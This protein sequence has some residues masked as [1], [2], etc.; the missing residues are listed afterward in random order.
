MFRKKKKNY[1]R[2]LE[3][4]EEHN[5]EKFI[6]SFKRSRVHDRILLQTKECGLGFQM[7]KKM[8]GIALFASNG[9]GTHIGFEKS[10]FENCLEAN[11][12]P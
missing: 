8:C 1:S 6:S 5:L 2:V 11:S 4:L 3:R 7:E 9:R 12:F 10:N